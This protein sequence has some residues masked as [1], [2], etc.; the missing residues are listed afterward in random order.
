MAKIPQGGVLPNFRLQRGFLASPLAIPDSN[1]CPSLAFLFAVWLQF[2]R[3]CPKR[4][5][6]KTLFFLIYCQKYDSFYCVVLSAKFQVFASVR[7]RIKATEYKSRY[8]FIFCAAQ[9][10]S[11][12]IIM[13][14]FKINSIHFLCLKIFFS[15]ILFTAF[16]N[17]IHK[18]R[19]YF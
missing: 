7:H 15:I 3:L 8:R 16:F 1:P 5:I 12:R 10:Y 19:H 17:W 11:E 2:V 13:S 14:E 6:R 4:R 18:Q 9:T